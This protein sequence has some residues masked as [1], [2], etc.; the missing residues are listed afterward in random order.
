M[1]CAFSKAAP[2]TPSVGAVSGLQRQASEGLVRTKSAL[3]RELSMSRE[4]IESI[5]R[6]L[7]SFS[8]ADLAPLLN[9]FKTKPSVQQTGCIHPS[10]FKAVL[11]QLIPPGPVPEM[12]EKS[13][14]F[15]GLLFQRSAE[16]TAVGQVGSLPEF[17]E[18]FCML[19]MLARGTIEEKLQLIFQTITDSGFA[20]LAGFASFVHAATNLKSVVEQWKQVSADLSPDQLETLP[21]AQPV[22][23]L[24]TCPAHGYLATAPNWD[25]LCEPNN[26]ACPSTRRACREYC[27]HGRHHVT[28]CTGAMQHTY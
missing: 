11:S 16:V 22:P 21:G 18:T 19:A 8:C 9:A 12:S 28:L 7:P 6:L 4:E 5:H 20:S 3:S 2:A 24:G 25:R 17:A 10:E 1:I 27:A 14:H 23:V 13:A 15:F 26:N